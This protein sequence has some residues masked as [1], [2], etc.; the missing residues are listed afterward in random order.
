M[1][2]ARSRRCTHGPQDWP[3]YKFFL[4]WRHDG[5]YTT[6]VA[7]NGNRIAP[8]DGNLSH[9]C[10][11]IGF[12]FLTTAEELLEIKAKPANLRLQNDRIH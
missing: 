2:A 9:K 10:K 11:K 7:C 1:C 8:L 3:D 4:K 6:A 5:N 12:H